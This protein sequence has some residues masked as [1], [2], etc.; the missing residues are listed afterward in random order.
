MGF[1]VAVADEL[2][3]EAL[4]ALP[5]DRLEIILLSYFAHM[6]DKVSHHIL[7]NCPFPKFIFELD[8]DD[9]MQE[10]KKAVVKKAVE[11]KKAVQLVKEAEESI[12]E[13]AQG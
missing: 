12:G 4:K 6:T 2:L 1:E 10:I 3:A 5:Q 7:K 8:E 9:V 11:R 13:E